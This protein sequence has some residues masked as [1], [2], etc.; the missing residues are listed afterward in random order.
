MA[1]LPLDP[2]LEK[3]ANH[4]TRLRPRHRVLAWLAAEGLSASIVTT[5]YDLL[6]DS[7]YRLAGMQ[8]LRPDSRLWTDPE[9]PLARARRLRLPLNR[10]YRHFTRIAQ[11][12]QFFSHGEAHESALIHKIHG[13]VE[14]YRL[15]RDG[16]DWEQV[17]KVLPSI[18][19]TFREIQNWRADSWSRDHLA[20][21][22]R[23]RTI[24]FAGYSA[25]DQV[26]HDTF[27]TVYEEV[28]NYRARAAEEHQPAAT[29][30][31]H[32]DGRRARAFFT[33][34]DG[35]SGFHGLE[36]LRAASL[37]SGDP[38]PELTDHVNLLTFFTDAARFPTL[39]ETFTWIYHLAARELQAQ[40]LESEVGRIGYQLF[41]RRFSGRGDPGTR[42]APSRG[43][44]RTK[45]RRPADSTPARRRGLPQRRMTA[46]RWPPR[47]QGS[48]ASGGGSS[49]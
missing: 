21:L 38:T 27:R 8:P 10:R 35:I 22:M 6:L 44:A 39:D 17:R 16:Q 19:F 40:A 41:D 34:R 24:V 1:G 13:C 25:V 3:V 29:E 20:T 26:I 5:N 9:D 46:R 36:I 31:T 49:A 32:K 33:D 14:T 7:A 18:V 2:D 43:S 11:A 42:W 37:A 28:G 47:R 4:A 45:P 30:P 15:A 23:T 12:T 48:P